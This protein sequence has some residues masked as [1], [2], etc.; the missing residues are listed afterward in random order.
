[1]TE[2]LPEK[3]EV[4]GEIGYNE[5]GTIAFVNPRWHRRRVAAGRQ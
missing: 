4:G 5:N 3:L 1:M 2:N